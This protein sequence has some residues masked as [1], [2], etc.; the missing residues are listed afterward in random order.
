MSPFSFHTRLL[1]LGSYNITLAISGILLG[2]H[3][4]DNHPLQNRK[5]LESNLP[6]SHVTI[7]EHDLHFTHKN[8]SVLA[9]M[10]ENNILPLFVSTACTDIMLL[11]FE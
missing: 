11:R 7:L 8:E 3:Q 2:R 10:R 5:I 6:E 4:E 9:I 1:F